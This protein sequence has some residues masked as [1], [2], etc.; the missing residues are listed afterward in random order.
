[1]LRSQE[2]PKDLAGLNELLDSSDTLDTLEFSY[3]HRIITGLLKSDL[4]LHINLFPKLIN[5]TDCYGMTPLSW[6]VRRRDIHSTSLLIEYGANVHTRDNDG[7]AALHNSKDVA[8]AKALIEAGADV[9][10]LS[11]TRGD[12]ATALSYAVHNADLELTQFLLT[13]GAN[14]NLSDYPVLY[15]AVFSG[16]LDL[17]ELL[18]DSGA[19]I[20][21]RIGGYSSIMY[22]AYLNKPECVRFFLERGAR[23]E[24][25]ADDGESLMDLVALGGGIAVMNNLAEARPQVFGTQP[26]DMNRYWEK[27]NARRD[28][29]YIGERGDI[30]E[31]REAF[32]RFLRSLQPRQPIQNIPD[33]TTSNHSTPYENSADGSEDEF[34]D[35]VEDCASTE[36]TFRI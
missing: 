30:E 35:A 27:F 21:S 32:A 25:V 31:E 7:L 6:A 5:A 28:M 8:C 2:D 24:F 36:V 13:C 18:V 34:F 3:L 22:A 1:M 15:S 14:P 17:I 26:K 9:N 4:E 19:N 33:Q 20:D 29:E 16:Q 11:T 10:S 12:R 23:L